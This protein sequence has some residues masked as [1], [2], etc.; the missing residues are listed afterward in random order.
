MNDSQKEERVKILKDR[1]EYLRNEIVR[2]NS[3]SDEMENEFKIM[4]RNVEKMIKIFKQSKFYLSVANNMTYD[5]NTIFNEN[6]V[7]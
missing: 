5:E 1:A 2:S 4:Q 7:I 3:E 6:N